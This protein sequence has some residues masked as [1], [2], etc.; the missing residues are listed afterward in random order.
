MIPKILHLIWLSGAPYPGLVRR[1]LRS[2]HRR[3]PDYEIKVWTQENFDIS[4]VR[5]VREAVQCHRWASASDYIRLWALWNYGGIYLDSDVFIRKSFD[6]LLNDGFFSAVEKGSG[7]YDYSNLLDAEGNLLDTGT[8]NVP[9]FGLQAAVM[10]SVPGHPFVRKC[11][12][13]YEKEPFLLPDGSLSIQTLIAPNVFARIAVDYGFRY[14]DCE[15]SLAEGIHILPSSAIASSLRHV[16]PRCM[17][18][19]CCNGNWNTWVK[20]S[21]RSKIYRKLFPLLL[22]RLDWHDR[23]FH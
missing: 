20:R 16:D 15:Q 7:V 11:M 17:A 3:F 12:E 8:W 23:L 13:W 10:G 4:Q 2:W 21:L 9:G 18:V 1:C 6:S 19:H 14:I 5:Y 22:A